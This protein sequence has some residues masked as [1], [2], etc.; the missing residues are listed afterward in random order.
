MI[1]GFFVVGALIDNSLPGHFTLPYKILAGLISSALILF[2]ARKMKSV[3]LRTP[4]KKE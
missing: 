2:V 3:V 4:L 1:I